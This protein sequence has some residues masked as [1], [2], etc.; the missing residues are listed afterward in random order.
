MADNWQTYPFEF[1]GG[2]ITNLSPLQQG[3]QAPGSA[4]VL[5]NFEPSILGGY[6]RING[7]EKYTSSIVPSYGDPKVQGSGQSGTTLII[8]NLHTSPAA[9]DQ[10]I[11]AGVTGTYTIASSGVSFDT[12]NKRATLTLTTSLASSPADKANV[13]FTTSKGKIIGV[14]AWQNKAIAV[15]NDNVYQSNGT[16]WNK[17]NVPSYGTVQVNGAT[18]TGSTLIVDG[19]TAAPQAGDTF[20]IAGVELVY[21]VTA[22]ATV[23]S[24]G[25]TLS[26]NPALDSSPANDAAITFLTA[27]RSGGLKN[28]FEKYRIGTTEKIVGV[29]SVNVPFIYDATTFTCLNSAPSDVVGAEHV[30]WFKNQLFFAKGDKL[31][32][33]SPYTDNDF[34]PANGAG[35]IGV[36]SAITGLVVFREQLIIFSQSRISQLVGNTLSD[37]VLK[38]ITLNIGCIDTDT[39]QEVGS[40]IM[41]LAPDGLR[42]LSGTDTFG[43]YGLAV[44][45]KVIQSE[46]TSFIRASTSFSSIVIK[47]KSQYR[48]F[49]YNDNITMQNAVGILGTQT[50]GDQ[51]G[52]LA[53]A[54]LRGIKAYVAD[55]DYNGRTEVLLFANE[56]GYVYRMESGNSFD[57]NNIIAEFSTPFVFI[58]DPRVRKT[59]YKLFLYTDPEAGVTTSVNLRLDFDDQGVV[60]PETIILSNV[61]ATAGIFGSN[62]ATY[63]TSVYGGSLKKLFQT[64]LVGSGFAASL[65]FVSNSIDAPF[66]LDAATLEFS[67]HDRR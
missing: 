40:D 55:G 30:V 13:T 34:N 45:S 2:L 18:Q 16:A 23:T 49:G 21:T 20:I 26:I 19:L 51:T 59:F 57:G 9:G 60:Q 62:T 10:L 28:R 6:R 61:S 48:I 14:A 31:T 35:T 36:G 41:F 39:I 25:A 56:D 53:W 63:G 64:Q 66:S 24:G 27:N 47:Q 1:R 44:V 7:Y 52:V 32:F 22:D 33:T 50:V 12:V 38:P 67:T 46:M 4:R 42:L 29:D 3:S 5:R 65:Q 37:F 58:N 17:I 15:R 8:S 43:D 11:I 54:E